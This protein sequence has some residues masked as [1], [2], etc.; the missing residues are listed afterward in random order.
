M[1]VSF[2]VAAPED[3]KELEWEAMGTSPITRRGEGEYTGRCQTTMKSILGGERMLR[4]WVRRDGKNDDNGK[5]QKTMWIL[6][7]YRELL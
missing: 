7:I 6:C 1:K 3:M 2:F 5:K 4:S